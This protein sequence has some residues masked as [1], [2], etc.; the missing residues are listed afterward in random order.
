MAEDKT[1]LIADD[2]QLICELLKR[3]IEWDTLGLKLAGEVYNG[4][5]LYEEILEKKPDIVITDI[6][7]PE[8]DGIELIGRIR[9]KGI[10]CHFVIVSGYRQFEYAHTALR[11][12]VEDYILKPVDTAELNN[13]LNK[14]VK[15]IEDKDDESIE[16][17]DAGQEKLLLKRFFLN[18]VISQLAQSPLTIQAIKEEYGII[19][20][21]FRIWQIY[22]KDI[23][24]P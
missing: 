15:K 21:A 4:R 3:I 9:Q 8:M 16:S 18:N 7:M 12:D 17:P 13:A 11:Y 20:N 5:A 10:P 14:L 22:L 19:L 24:L 2:E 1:V 6:S 23:I